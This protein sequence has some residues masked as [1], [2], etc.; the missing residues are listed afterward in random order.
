MFLKVFIKI[1]LIIFI[2]SCNAKNSN[3]IKVLRIASTTSVSESGLLA[4][5]TPIFEYRYKCKIKYFPRGSGKAL[6]M[7]KKGEVDLVFV[8]AKKAEM[9]FIQEGFGINRIE[10]MSNNFALLGPSNNNDNLR[11]MK[12]VNNAFKNIAEKQL[13]F[14]SRADNSGT[15]M[16]ENEIW[17]QLSIQPEG[18][19]YLKSKSSML[20]TLEMASKQKAYTLSDK[21]TYLSHK[22]K[23]NLKVI[24]E[25][26]P[27][28][29]NIY[30]LIAVNPNT[31][32]DVNYKSAMDFISFLSSLE[33]QE[34]I[35]GF[36]QITYGKT[37]FTPILKKKG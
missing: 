22:N 7:A 29:F 9:K 11:E 17:H 35:N 27:I 19:W 6:D 10:I 8:H 25:G 18:E 23:L 20:N 34:L 16:I 13:P 2:F 30:S 4:V 15:N 3:N 36:G 33:G 26:D 37:L 1:L 5:L 14:V 21:A 32:A 12:N 28:L 24:Q 31:F